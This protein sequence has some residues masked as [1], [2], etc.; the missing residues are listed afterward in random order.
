MSLAA[1]LIDRWAPILVG[2]DLK[3]AD[4][5]RFLVTCDGE[6]VFDKAAEGRHALPGEVVERLSPVIGP[7][8]SWR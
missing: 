2:V 6:V 8:L 4:K 7:K 3:T 1:E 5:G